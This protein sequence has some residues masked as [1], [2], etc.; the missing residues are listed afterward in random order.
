MGN[1]ERLK[2]RTGEADEAL[3]NDLLESAKAV[4]LYPPLSFWKRN[5]SLGSQIRGLTA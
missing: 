1:L 4:I 3:L 2:S 5:R